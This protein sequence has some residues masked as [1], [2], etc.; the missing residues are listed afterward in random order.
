MERIVELEY[1]YKNGV[2]YEYVT[3]SDT[4]KH[5]VKWVYK[6]ERLKSVVLAG[7][8]LISEN[9]LKTEIIVVNLNDREFFVRNDGEFMTNLLDIND[10]E[11]RL[12][13]EYSQYEID[14]QTGKTIEVYPANQQDNITLGRFIGWV[15]MDIQTNEMWMFVPSNSTLYPIQQ[16]DLLLKNAL[17]VKDAV[18]LE[19]VVAMESE[20]GKKEFNRNDRG[21]LIVSFDNGQVFVLR[22]A[23]WTDVTITPEEKL[24]MELE[25]WNIA[26]DKY[27]VGYD[28]D[29]KI[30]MR[31]KGPN[32][33]V[34]WD[35]RWSSKVIVN[36]V[37]ALND[38]Q[39]TEFVPASSVANWSENISLKE[40]RNYT[41]SIFRNSDL[42]IFE[43]SQT[44]YRPVPF[45]DY[46]NCWGVWIGYSLDYELFL[47]AWP[48]ADGKVNTIHVFD[49]E[50]Y[51]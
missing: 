46:S 4:K 26:L 5:E 48:Q 31:E 50:L 37:I 28:G 32:R 34:Y 6:H 19:Q 13:G 12:L 33:L 22:N 8:S 20:K 21:E 18:L 30:E 43:F 49:A 11:Y 38:C 23:D 1:Q 15:R 27:N 41:G 39:A 24:N 10:Q 45:R 16:A 17:P 25:R 35:G 42:D 2:V 7:Y 9:G 3:T 14:A 36:M 29:G 40:F 51:K 44:F 47:F